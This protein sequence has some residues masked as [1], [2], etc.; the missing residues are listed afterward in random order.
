M[1]LKHERRHGLDGGFFIL[2]EG[3][4]RNLGTGVPINKTVAQLWHLV[5][6]PRFTRNKYFTKCGNIAHHAQLDF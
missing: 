6:P 1:D 4:F 3:T 5:K 2:K